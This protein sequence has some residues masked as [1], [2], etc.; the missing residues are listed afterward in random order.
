[1]K[2]IRLI[3]SLVVAAACGCGS[4]HTYDQDRPPTDSLVY[5][6]EGLQAKD[7]TAATDHMATDL[8]ALPELNGSDKKWT[9][10]LTGV[11]NNSSDPT[12]NYDIFSERL[13]SLLSG[14]G[15][16]RVAL[17]ENKAQYHDLQNKELENTGDGSN[18]V[19][20]VQPDYGLA[21][22][23]DDMPNRSSNYYLVNATL[24]NLK[25]REITWTAYPPYEVQTAR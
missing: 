24:T 21:I 5:G 6:N 16:G 10:V 4:P 25:T 19:A 22:K 9:I 2:S 13:K 18:H 17:I 20:G 12:L 7:V 15:H 8:L 23:V 3:S 11:T 14:K 1:M